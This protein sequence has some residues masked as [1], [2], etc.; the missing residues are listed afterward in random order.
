MSPIGLEEPFLTV[1]PVSND[2][3]AVPLVF[4]FRYVLRIAW[5]LG[6]QA[7]KM[8]VLLVGGRPRGSSDGQ[9]PRL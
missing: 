1:L 3:V 8:G 2:L 4:S 7:W 5:T 6:R 9:Y